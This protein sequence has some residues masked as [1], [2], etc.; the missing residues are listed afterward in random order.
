M[1]PG[2]YHG[3]GDLF[4]SAFLAALLS[5]NNPEKAVLAA[6]EVSYRAVK[7][8]QESGEDPRY[9]LCFEPE[10]PFLW[11]KIGAF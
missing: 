3:T 10:L 9:G 5:C 2:H 11:Q 8:T 1:V 7:R 6:A 4:S